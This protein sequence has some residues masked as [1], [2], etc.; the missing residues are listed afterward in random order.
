MC[1][2]KILVES[3][4]SAVYSFNVSAANFGIFFVKK[5]DDGI[6]RVLH[7]PPHRMNV[8]AFKFAH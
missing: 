1:K 7:M 3:D 5:M 6:F 8:C 2:Q 4:N